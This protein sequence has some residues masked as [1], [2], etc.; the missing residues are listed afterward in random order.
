MKNE[1][2]DFGFNYGSLQVSRTANDTLGNAIIAIKTPK[3]EFS[4]RA[5]KTGQMRFF[6]KAGNEC[7][8][9]SIDHIDHLE[10]YYTPFE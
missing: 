7:E 9:V 1:I 6:D 8:L 2:T 10:S 4:I 3:A 5:T